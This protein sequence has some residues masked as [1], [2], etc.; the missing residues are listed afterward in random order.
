GCSPADVPVYDAA[1]MRVV[2]CIGD[3]ARYGNGVG[4]GRLSL[5][6]EP[7]AKGFALDEGHREPEPAFHFT[8]VEDAED[9]RMLERDVGHAGRCIRCMRPRTR[10]SARY[11]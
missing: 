9:V 10:G 5:A 11:E 4:D 7:V 3:L 2:E 8:G 6:F 1:G